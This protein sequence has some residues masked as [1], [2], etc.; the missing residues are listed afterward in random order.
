MNETI[1]L[2]KAE[3][4]FWKLKWHEAHAELRKANKGLRRLRA[5]KRAL[6]K[7]HDLSHTPDVKA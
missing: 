7:Q 5:G 4:N 2:L 3:R 1:E 6:A